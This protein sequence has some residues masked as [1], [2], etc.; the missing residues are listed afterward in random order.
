[1]RAGDGTPAC[2]ACFVIYDDHVDVL[3]VIGQNERID[4]SMTP[5]AADL[6]Q[7]GWLRVPEAEIVKRGM[8]HRALRRI[9]YGRR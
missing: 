3:A 5:D 7:R 1:M 8:S 2:W 9:A 4:R 6:Q